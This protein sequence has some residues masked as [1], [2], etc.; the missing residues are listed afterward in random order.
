VTRRIRPHNRGG[1]KRAFASVTNFS[2]IISDFIEK[3]M[4]IFGWSES[5]WTNYWLHVLQTEF[6]VSPCFGLF[7]TIALNRI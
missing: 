7:T 6:L 3:V 4:L 2:G 1:E 5:P